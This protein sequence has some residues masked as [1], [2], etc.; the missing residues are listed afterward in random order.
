M[1]LQVRVVSIWRGENFGTVGTGVGGE[2]GEM[3]GLHVVL[4]GSEAGAGLGEAALG[5]LILPRPQ[6]GDPLP[7]QI[8]DQLPLV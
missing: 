7:D 3:P 8:A 4:E 6:L 1:N 5:A 2:V